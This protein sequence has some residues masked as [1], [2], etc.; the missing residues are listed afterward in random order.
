MANKR[1][2]VK[3]M[4]KFLLTAILLL[5]IVLPM[6]AQQI[7]VEE[8]K[9]VKKSLFSSAKVSKDKQRATLDLITNEKGF[10]FSANGTT[11]AEATEG[12]G[13]ITLLLP[14]KTTFLVIKHP[15]YGQTTWKPKKALKRKK[16]YQA[17]L[18]TSS[19]NKVFKPGKQWLVFEISPDN[20]IIHVDSTLNK[21][22]NGKAQYFLPLG[23]HRYK[24]ESP[25]HQAVEDSVVLSDTARSTI[26]VILQPFYS[27]LTVKT[28]SPDYEIYIDDQRMGSGEATSGHL[29]PGSHQVSIRNKRH[30]RIQFYNETLFVGASEKRTITLTSDNLSKARLLEDRHQPVIA[31][32]NLTETQVATVEKAAF[33]QEEPT[34]KAT[35]TA[36]TLI[37]PNDSS[38]IWL[39][40]EA[41]GMGSWEGQL[42]Q[43]FYLVTTRM[44]QIESKPFFFWVDN[45][46]PLTLNLSGPMEDHGMLNI[47]GNEI[48]AEVYINGMLM[49]TTPCI[50]DKLPT[51]HDYEIT[52]R[53][54][55]FKDHSEKVKLR[56]NDI[57]DV[58]IKL[59]KH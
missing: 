48:D 58:N 18:H 38:E 42:Q 31:P 36:V 53:K 29:S 34:R 52:L 44:G 30:S 26:P 4:K 40:H 14:H 5:G 16:H 9:R 45:E 37:A 50:I 15:D 8:F 43:G 12:D 46:F 54:P 55:G 32:T 59:K 49:G 7:D 21:V 11:P 47:H 23:T 17:Y 24:I 10:E 6:A 57:V 2:Y 56:G 35:L 19:P 41:V 3:G 22:R 1:T 13:V 39:N 20:A 51:S 25:F 27:Y 33:I 28:P